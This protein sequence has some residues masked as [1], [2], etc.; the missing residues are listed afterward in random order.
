M[1]ESATAPA[2]VLAPLVGGHV[3]DEPDADVAQWDQ[4]G[5]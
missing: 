3:V 5:D 2:M 4:P 1:V